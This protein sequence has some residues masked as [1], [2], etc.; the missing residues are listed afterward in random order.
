MKILRPLQAPA[1]IRAL[2]LL[3]ALLS[4]TPVCAEVLYTDTGS[5]TN[6]PWS[7]I[8]PTLNVQAPDPGPVYGS[9]IDV[10]NAAVEVG[11]YGNRPISVPSQRLHVV[12]NTSTTSFASFTRWFQT[13][14]NT[15][16]VRLFVNDENTANTRTNTARTEVFHATGWN[17][18]DNVTYEWTGRYTI[19]HRQQGYALFQSKNDD[20]D[21]SV[22]LNI[23][24]TGRLTVNNRVSPDVLVTNLD[25]SVKDFDGLGFDVRVLDDGL[26]YKVWIDG[27]LY[28]SSSYSRPTGPTKFRWGSYLGASTLVPPSDYNL[29]LVSGVQIKSWPGNLAT[30]TTAITKA[31][32]TTSLD[33]GASWVGGT[34]PG[35]Y[36]QAVWNSTVAGA[37]TTTLGSDQTW[38]GLKIVN[39]GGLV[40][41]NGSDILSLDASGLDM[42]AATQNLVVN[43][44]VQMPVSSLWNVAAGRTATF[45][46]IIS[47]YPGLT[48]NGGGNLLL[49][50]A[51]IYGGN[52]IV[53]NGT[54]VAD[55]NSALST[56][57]LLLN[58][59]SLSN[60]ASCTLG[61]DV[62]LNSS[63]TVGVAA[64]QTLTLNGVIG[65]ANS[66][67]KSGSGTLTLS[68]TNTY[69]GA[70]TIGAGTLQLG[71]LSALGG[72]SAITI[73]GG[74]IL[75][76]TID[77]ITLTA[78]ITL[79]DTGTTSQINA[80]GSSAGS[81]VT[82]TLTLNGAIGG[83]GNLLLYGAASLNTGATIL[84]GAQSTYAGNTK[85][86]TAGSGN[87]GQNLNVKLGVANALPVT[88]V[89]TLDGGNG[90]GSGRTV[91]LDLNGHDQTLSG[92]TNSQPD[93]Q[94][95]RK[96]FVNN[97]GPLATLSVSNNADYTFG[98]PGYTNVYSGTTY[99]QKAQI[100]GAI[101]LAKQ[102]TG[103]LT[104]V[105]ANTYTGDTIISAGTLALGS[106]TNAGVVISVGSI[107]KSPNII[108]G[109]APGSPAIL[110]VTEVGITIDAAQSLSGHGTVNGVVTNN[111]TL[112]P[113]T[114]MGVLTLNSNLVLN[115]GSTNTFEIDGTT[116]A[117]DTVVL[118]GA[119]TYGGVL[120][121][122][123]NGSFTNGQSFTLF[124]GSGA[125]DPSN[126]ETIVVE[127][128]V[129]GT[130][131]TFTNGVLTAVV[132]SGPSGPATLTNSYSSGVLTLTWPAGEGW[133]LK[134][135]TNSLS[136]GLNTHTNA[137]FTV[138]G[139]IDG[140]NSI[141]ID[142]NQPT[143]FY[144]LFWTSGP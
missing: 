71:N 84:L 118:G 88:T 24:G 134:N 85:L 114:S 26:F 62:E 23:S 79:G 12:C 100:I 11:L 81:G 53:S 99:S 15:H 43:C 17:Y 112:A 77:G 98:I 90:S 19:A 135:Q 95:G 143:V 76:P 93:F 13:D 109:T 50:A 21:W 144:R 60:S 3:S 14:G 58:G 127:P 92:L 10:N 56:G 131:F 115:S 102:G 28:A 73:A 97:T 70:T 20:N 29:I 139:G 44:R 74:A 140:S 47:G 48:L 30:A 108:V 83:D 54:L 110:D 25:G 66:L 78:P 68:G 5:P 63:A 86:D 125:T 16:V 35:L 38:A 122:V 69:T 51:N 46:G 52:T 49:S 106:A 111:G 96:Q 33:S 31:N 34:A 107:K 1:W 141:A 130:S 121:I 8:L 39:P 41:I 123:P 7:E 18:A 94:F 2:V 27:V 120:Q 138:P 87:S 59:G 137:W 6:P 126:F 91:Q 104:L 9:V 75:R 67:T 133:V 119:V 101:A 36:N 142:P 80:P 105:S 37:N 40:T 103:K 22:Q 45:N 132:S 64:L 65:G 55:N 113:G 72:A 136:A 124:S 116:P 32:N 42:S 57:L 82:Q 89:L 117:N 4:V 129:S 128:P 61:N